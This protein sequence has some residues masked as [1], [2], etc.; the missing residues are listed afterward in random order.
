MF[1]LGRGLGT[2]LQTKLGYFS[3]NT[4]MLK[5]RNTNF[6]LKHHSND[7]LSPEKGKGR[8]ISLRI[9]LPSNCIHKIRR[10]GLNSIQ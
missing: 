5:I 2:Q 8:K 10:P 3:R 1:F 6:K 9:V 7:H 4:E